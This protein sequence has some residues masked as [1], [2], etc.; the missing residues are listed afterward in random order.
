MN[1]N[2]S[3]THEEEKQLVLA[4]RNNERFNEIGVKLGRTDNSIKQRVK[5]IIFDNIS[6]INDE[7]QILKVNS[8][9]VLRF[10]LIISYKPCF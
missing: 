4:L 10:Y 5:K 3:W 6:D 2:K 8:F 1:K 9:M 7:K